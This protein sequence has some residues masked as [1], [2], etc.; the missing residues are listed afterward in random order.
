[1]LTSPFASEINHNSTEYSKHLNGLNTHHA[2][3]YVHYLTSA[4]LYSCKHVSFCEWEEG[5]NQTENTPKLINSKLDIE[6]QVL[7][8]NTK[9]THGRKTNNLES[10]FVINKT[11]IICERKLASNKARFLQFFFQIKEI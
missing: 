11:Q 7:K 6:Q 9:F 10:T 1:M 5:R 8:N 3:L 2:V 4:K